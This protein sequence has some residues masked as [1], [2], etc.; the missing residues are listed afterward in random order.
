[1]K[2]NA[3]WLLL[4]SLGVYAIFYRLYSVFL[5]RR[6]IE[7]DDSRPTPAHTRRDG[8][9]FHPTNRWVLWGYHFAAISG[10]GP[11]IG[12]VLAA[13]AVRPP[14]RGLQR[15]AQFRPDGRDD[16]VRPVR[17]RRRLSPLDEALA[18]GPR[19]DEG[20]ARVVLAG[21]LKPPCP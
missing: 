2:V 8:Q 20:R 10:A 7:L 9:N 17:S 11:L 19:G 4:G 18:D 5:A 6:V 14:G 12:P 15:L 13:H 21:G 16:G 1:M 3:F